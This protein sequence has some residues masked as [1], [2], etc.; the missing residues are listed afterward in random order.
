M[1]AS[2][3][4]PHVHVIQLLIRQQV[5]KGVGFLVY[6]HETWKSPETGRPYLVLPARKTVADPLAPSLHGEPLEAFVNATM[7]GEFGLEPDDF[8]L[9][10]EAGST[11]VRMPA[12]HSGIRKQFALCPV[13]VWVKPDAREP[14]R[15]RLQGQWLTWG[16]IM[17]HPDASPALRAVFEHLGLRDA[18]LA[19]R[20]A[21]KPADEARD[22]SPHRLLESVPDRPSMYALARRWF[23]R[24]LGGVRHL[25][26]SVID[27][28]LDAGNRAFNLR[29]ADPYLRYQM[30]GQGF[31]WSFFTHKDPQ[32]I[33]VHSAPVVEIYGVLAGRLAVWWKPYYNRGT[34]AWH[35]QVLEPG[36]WIEVDALQC[37]LVHWLTE[38]KGVV[39]KAGP[40]PL[41]EVGRL[42]VKGKT[43]CADCPCVKPPEVL[44]LLNRR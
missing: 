35:R 4:L 17:K 15:E 12:V 16:E 18:E 6:A 3:E 20:Y 32:D 14:L 22:E 28:V 27:E 30:Q 43:T 44:A 8:A 25:P 11:A 7:Q 13:D 19:T 41:A 23:S 37:H 31:T 5:P 39:F 34:S 10:E 33:H 1:S 29:V 24:N 42:G 36:D 26:G 38:G 40:G 9:A 2:G 21:S